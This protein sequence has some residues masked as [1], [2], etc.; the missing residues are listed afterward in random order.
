MD[1]SAKGKNVPAYLMMF[2]RLM[3]SKDVWKLIAQQPSII[4][5]VQKGVRDLGPGA[6]F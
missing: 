4:F 3:P 5:S 2:C 6:E 1:C